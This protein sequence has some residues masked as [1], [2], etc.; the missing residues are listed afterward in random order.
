MVLN[1]LSQN[2]FTMVEENF[3]FCWWKMPKNSNQLS[4]NIFTV[5]EENFGLWWSQM[6]KNKGFEPLI[7]DYLHHCSR[8]F[9]ILMSQMPKNNGFEPL[10]SI[11]IFTIEE[12]FGFWWPE[13]PQSKVFEPLK[14]TFCRC[15]SPWL[16]NIFDFDD[17]K[18]AIIKYFSK[19]T[20][21]YF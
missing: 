13:M 16:K 1:H 14:P 21:L 17:T 4:Q 8:K 7:T 9:W 20:T 11:Y 10:I 15:S 3:G 2:I 5:A 6:S 12:S 18:C 19:F